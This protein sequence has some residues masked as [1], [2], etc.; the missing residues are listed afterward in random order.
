MISTLKAEHLPSFSNRGPGELGNGLF[1]IVFTLLADC[2]KLLSDKVSILIM[3]SN[4][5]FSD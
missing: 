1:N 2:W 4:S 5:L 3:G